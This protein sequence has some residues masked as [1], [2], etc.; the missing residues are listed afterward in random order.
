MVCHIFLRSWVNSKHFCDLLV[1]PP[2]FPRPSLCGSTG[3]EW[4]SPLAALLRLC[5]ETGC[6]CYLFTLFLFLF[7]GGLWQPLAVV[8]IVTLN[9]MW[10]VAVITSLS[11]T[12]HGYHLCPQVLGAVWMMTDWLCHSDHSASAVSCS[13]IFILFYTECH[14][15]IFHVSK[16]LISY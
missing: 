16:W 7:I 3:K 11:L 10:V 6:I 15:Q 12:V 14:Q 1:F 2:V 9:N 8:L 5:T 13:I 4:I